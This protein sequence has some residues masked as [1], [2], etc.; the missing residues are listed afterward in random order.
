M[1][2]KQKRKAISL[3]FYD[4]KLQ[5]GG[6][7]GGGFDP[8][9]GLIFLFDSPGIMFIG[10]YNLKMILSFPLIEFIAFSFQSKYFEIFN[11]H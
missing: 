1:K 6:G 4:I 3:Y 5:G 11:F 8:I 2:A 7:G 9:S 10:E